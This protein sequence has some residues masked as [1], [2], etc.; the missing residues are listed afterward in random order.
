[1]NKRMIVVQ[2][3]V[4]DIIFGSSNQI[5]CDEVTKLMQKEFA[6]SFIGNFFFF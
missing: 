5:I 6:M 2:I 1:M 3:Y 4:D